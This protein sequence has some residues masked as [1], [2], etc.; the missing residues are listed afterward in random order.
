MEKKVVF[1]E[2]VFGLIKPGNTIKEELTAQDCNVLHMI[3]GLSGEVGELLDAIKK[4]IIYRKPLDIENVLEEV[5]DIEFF[6]EGF[7]QALG[8]TRQQTI[9]AN[10]AKLS[11]RYSGLTYSDEAAKARADKV[12][13]A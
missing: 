4:S 8:F 12:G 6:L 7:R 1:E 9:D 3:L 2:M 11:V 5:G 13:S 10:I